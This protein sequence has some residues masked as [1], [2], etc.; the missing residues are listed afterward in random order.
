MIS[1][2]LESI[3]RQK[4]N[5]RAGNGVAAAHQTHP[6]IEIVAAANIHHGEHQLKPET[7]CFL[8]MALINVVTVHT[9]QTKRAIANGD[10]PKESAP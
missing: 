5:K 4:R 8:N 2:A 3:S 1:A 7:G 9:I 10:A 6:D